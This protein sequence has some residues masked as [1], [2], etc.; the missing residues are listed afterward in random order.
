M[1]HHI[2]EFGLGATKDPKDRQDF[3]LAGIAGVEEVKTQKFE[4]PEHFDPNNQYNRGSCTS[5][6]QAHHKERQEH[7]SRS[8][9][10]IMALTKQLEGNT[11]YGAYTRNTF[12]IVNKEGA[13]LE[14]LYP[15]PDLTMSWEKY[16]DV[17]EIPKSCHNDAKQHKSQSYWRVGKSIDELRLALTKYKNSVVCS[18]SWYKE[19]NNV[20]LLPGGI[21]PKIFKTP[22]GGHAVEAVGFDDYKRLIK[23]KNSWGKKW[24]VDGY[25]YMP[26]DIFLN[27][28][29]DLWCSLD[30]PNDLPVDLY[31]GQK[32]TWTSYMRE[33]AM[34]FNPWLFRKIKRLPNHREIKALAYGFWG[35]EEVF[36]GS[37]G[38]IWLEHTK[39][40]AKK[41]GLIK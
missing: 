31:Y 18:M 15:E 41:I 2:E 13:C 37:V 12:K 16:I 9:R 22:V 27:V 39:P 25:F 28:V 36:E 32:R 10:F 5:Q 38:E 11:R 24:G 21:L 6:A 1:S 26:Y 8:A 40:G 33:R 30:I 4:L 23:F 19:F 7:S 17:D 3:R 29:W 14:K 20:G 35:Y 34:A